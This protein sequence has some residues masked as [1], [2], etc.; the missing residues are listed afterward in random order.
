MA[1]PLNPVILPL[2]PTPATSSWMPPTEVDLCHVRLPQTGPSKEE[3]RL[4]VGQ[5]VEALI[6]HRENDPPGW[7]VGTLGKIK[8]DLMVVEFHDRDQT[9]SDIVEGDCVRPCNQK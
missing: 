6:P 5:A 4:R 8:G 9:Y 7:W 2:G 3:Q 1:P